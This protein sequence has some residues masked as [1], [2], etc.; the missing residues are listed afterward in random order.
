MRADRFTNWQAN[1]LI[2]PKI[3]DKTLP[4]D[5]FST[6]FQIYLRD[7]RLITFGVMS[8]YKCSVTALVLIVM[9]GALLFLKYLEHH[10]LHNE[11]IVVYLGEESAL[12]EYRVSLYD[13][14]LLVSGENLTLSQAIKRKLSV[15]LAQDHRR[16]KDCEVVEIY[17]NLQSGVLVQA[18][19]KI[20]DKN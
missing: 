5:Y 2:R 8:N 9:I 12:I 7:R 20:F 18:N 11:W 17:G 3:P 14:R 4:S 1:T 16:L 19:C 10:D 6:A 13:L 15:Q